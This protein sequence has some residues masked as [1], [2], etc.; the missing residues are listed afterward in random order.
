MNDNGSKAPYSVKK[1]GKNEL[2]AT[3][4]AYA[5]STRLSMM[6]ELADGEIKSR[7]ERKYN[8]TATAREVS[9]KSPKSRAK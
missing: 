8:K 2:T 5:N 4:K 7:F 9:R 3:S 6:D 1:G